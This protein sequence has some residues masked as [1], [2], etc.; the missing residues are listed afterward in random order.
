LKKGSRIRNRTEAELL[1]KQI[2][3]KEISTPNLYRLAFV[4]LCELFLDELYITNNVEVLDEVNPLIDNFLIFAERQ[5]SYSYLVE[6]KLLQAKLALIQMEFDKAKQLLTQAQ[7]VAETHGL[8][9]LA[10]KISNEHDNLLEHLNEWV[11][12]QKSGAPMSERI[13]LASF[14][15]VV[16]RM[17]GK[18]AIE[19]PQLVHEESVLLL[20]IGEG[21]FPIFSTQFGE[22]YK[23]EEDLISGFLTAF[24][25]FSSELFSKG[26]DRAKI[27]EYMILMQAV[28][29]FSVCYLF[30]GQ[31]YLAKQKLTKFIERI[32]NTTY[33]WETLNKFYEMNQIIELKNSPSLELLISEIFINTRP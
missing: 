3:E 8:S 9:L 11:N 21:G 29:P 1:L 10:S 27:G 23:L 26:L 6:T 28:K 25:N 15:G 32:Q 7:R 2:T 19:I 13:K 4:N 33:I 31:T 12:L 18:R 14:N 24:N 22:N 5:N 17:Q 30:K 20:I 16:D